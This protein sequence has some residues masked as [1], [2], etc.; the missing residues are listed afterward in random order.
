MWSPSKSGSTGDMTYQ[1]RTYTRNKTDD[2]A[3]KIRKQVAGP[4]KTHTN[5]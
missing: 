2:V 3:E 4:H 5:M 1:R